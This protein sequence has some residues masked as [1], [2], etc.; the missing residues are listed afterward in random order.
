MRWGGDG[1]GERRRRRERNVPVVDFSVI[2]RGLE[3]YLVRL[4]DAV[5]SREVWLLR[6]R[7]L[8]FVVKRSSERDCVL[9]AS[10]VLAV[11]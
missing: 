10:G 8:D 11:G 4:W 9:L 6:T 2:V 5:S 3:G 1:D 7:V